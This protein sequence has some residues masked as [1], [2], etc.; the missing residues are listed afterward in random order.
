MANSD[1]IEDHRMDNYIHRN[2]DGHLVFGG[3]DLIDLANKHGTPLYV[4]NEPMIRSNMRRYFERLTARY[5]NSGVAYAGKAFLTAWICSI[6]AEEGLYLDV[7]SGGELFTALAAG[8]PPKRIFFHGNNKS[9][10]EITMGLEAGIGRF[11]VD[12]FYEMDTLNRLANQ[13]GVKADIQIRTTPG[14]E[15]DTHEYVE[16]GMLDSKF[17]FGLPSGDALKAVKFALSSKSLRLWGIH[18]H[19]G[20]Q[21]LNLQGPVLATQRIIDFLVKIRQE[22]GIQLDE[23]NLGGGLGIAYT[24][25]D[26]APSIEEYLDVMINTV[27]TACDENGLDHPRIYFEPGRSI[28]SP[29]G[30]T[31]YTVGA[32]KEIPG[33]RKYVSVDGGMGD[34]PRPSLYKSRYEAALVNR[35]SDEKS[36]TV[37]LAGKCCESGDV[38][39]KDLNIPPLRSGDIIA[40]FSTGAY[41]YSMASNYNR[42]PRPAVV[43]VGDGNDKVVVRRES[44]Q[45]IVARDV[46]LE[47]HSEAAATAR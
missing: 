3:C 42:L 13:M 36:E 27:M 7:V 21:I 25:S 5:S 11:I 47:V 18:T 46:F 44:Y 45:D 12:N 29:A 24:S 41:N 28:V 34:N 43:A 17:G 20:S 26:N 9:I 39:I 31:L 30:L 6:A 38:L 10:S 1:T 15:A 32:I 8:F 40:V 35:V 19:I 23:L 37:T 14:I 16:T 4:M 22:T 33:V 2:K